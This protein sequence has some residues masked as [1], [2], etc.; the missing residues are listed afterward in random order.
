MRSSSKSSGFS[1]NAVAGSNV[2]MLGMDM[3]EKKCPGLMG[4]AIHRTD[5]V[6]DEAYWMRG[7]KVFKAGAA[8]LPLGGMVSTRRHPIQGFTW[9][10]YSAKPNYEYTYRIAALEGTPERLKERHV[11]EVSV[12][13][14]AY[15]EGDHNVYFN[16]GAAASQEFARRFR[17]ERPDTL[18][19]PAF[20]WLSR[21]L[22]EGILNFIG[23]AEGK[24][25]KLRVAAYEFT[26]PQVLQSLRDAH[27]RGADVQIIYHARERVSEKTSVK[28]GKTTITQ[29]GR[30]RIAV[31]SARIKGLC[32]ERQAKPQDISHNKFI[33]L[34]KGNEPRAVLTGS[35]NFTQGGIF[36]HS[37]VVHI[38]EQAA[39]ARA[40]LDY[41]EELRKDPHKSVLGPILA[42]AC[43]LAEVDELPPRGTTTVFSPRDSTAALD[44]YGRLAKE[45]SGA[46]F[47]SF[48]FGMHET[49]QSAYRNG[50]A[51]LRYALMEKM[52]VPRR[53][54]DKT[55][56]EV[57]KIINLRKMPE[58]RFA[59]GGFLETNSFDR[60]LV[61]RLTGLNTHVKYIHTK[62]MLIDPLGDDPIVVS[63]SA[64]FSEPSCNKNDEN[65]LIIRGNERV[66]H[67]YLGEFMRLYNHFAYREWV[68]SSRARGRTPKTK[69]LDEGDNW[70]RGYFAETPQSRQREYFARC[71][72]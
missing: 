64:N 58:N 37:N 36:G 55:K 38:V 60:W 2:V 9:A 18:G 32:H 57:Q 10:D 62:Y 68:R 17:N 26:E 41:W 22:H 30:N 72:R 46:L 51:P 54:K 61:E 40:Y 50:L 31:A 23:R 1:V 39:V 25:W 69:Y 5:H 67:I 43:P 44:F 15:R 59:V 34:L 27:L 20:R 4:F 19:A 66:A 12:Q 65:M 52:V 47:M 3:D 8:D 45:A 29:T 7:M 16:R 14:E 6:E 53:D 71:V 13:T 11:T 21:G 24:R 33:V 42:A 70:W 48:A 28:T 63:G 49:F 56:A 35:T